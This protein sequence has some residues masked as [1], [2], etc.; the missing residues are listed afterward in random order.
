[1]RRNCRATAVA[2][3]LMLAVISRAENIPIPTASPE[4][5]P[6]SS[7]SG[8]PDADHSAPATNAAPA[9]GGNLAYP[10]PDA[11]DAPAMKS[12]GAGMALHPAAPRPG[13]RRPGLWNSVNTSRKVVALTFDDGPHPK[14]TPQLLD[15]LQREG[16]H[17]TF[18]V[19]GNLA[20]AHPAILQRM[21]AEGHEVAN[22]SWD[23]P[24]LP[25]LS[26]EKFAQ[27]IRKTSEI[28]ERN[29]GQKV[30]LMRPTYGLYNERVEH[31][32]INDYG[33]DIILWSVDPNDWKKPGASVVTRRLVSGAHPGAILLAHDIHPGTIAAMPQAIAQLKAQGYQFATVSELL[34]MDEAPQ[35]KQTPAPGAI[36]VTERATSPTRP[37]SKTSLPVG[38]PTTN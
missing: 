12:T 2:A 38:I 26:E 1:M 27:Q 24:R 14:L 25:R 36:K 31:A 10:L 20:A 8:C 21:A 15:V 33:L 32:L 3:S 37:V 17:A 29:T 18:F 4:S 30:T 7:L 35:T 19:L 23:H 28:I 34:A 6:S 11:T 16:V 9:P 13:R 22:H 5:I